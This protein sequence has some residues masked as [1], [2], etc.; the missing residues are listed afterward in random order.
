LRARYEKPRLPLVISGNLGPRGDGYR[1]DARM[2]VDDARRYHAAQINVFAATDADL[3]SAF[4]LNYVDE[5]V[6]IVQAARDAAM[7]VVISFTVETD[8]RLPSGEGLGAAIRRT[9]QETDGY[10]AYFMLNCA[11]PDHFRELDTLDPDVGGRIRGLRA[12]ASR[13]SHAELDESTELDPGDP[14]E[15]GAQYRA[16]RDRLPGLRVLGGCCGT[17]HRHVAAIFAACA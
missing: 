12:N 2:S 8:G 14:L 10:P 11:H 16:L 1:A 7:P 15:L 4:T 9:D 13:K 3:V 6:G 17:D 5:A